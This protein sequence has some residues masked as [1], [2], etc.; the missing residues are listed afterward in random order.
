MSEVDKQRYEV[1]A[2]EKAEGIEKG[3]A[4]LL[5][6]SRGEVQAIL[7]SHGIPRDK[8][9]AIADQVTQHPPEVRYEGAGSIAGT[10]AIVVALTRL[11]KVLVPLLEPFSKQGSKLAYNIAM[12]ILKMLKK[13]LFDQKSIRLTEKRPAKKRKQK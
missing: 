9:D 13:K 2:Q 6:D 3:A 7:E 4:E 8:V 10:I 11:I 1:P 12:D 5:L